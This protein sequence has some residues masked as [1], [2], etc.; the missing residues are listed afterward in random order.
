MP[1]RGFLT[2]NSSMCTILRRIFS[3]TKFKLVNTKTLMDNEHLYIKKKK[4]MMDIDSYKS[5][6]NKNRRN[7]DM[8]GYEK[9]EYRR[10]LIVFNKA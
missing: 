9:H 8:N 6:I 5:I 1:I 3:L 4:T 7:I 2:P 10:V